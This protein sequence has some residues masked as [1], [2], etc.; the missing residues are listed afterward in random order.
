[1]AQL[2]CAA[3]GPRAEEAAQRL[4]ERFGSLRT[5]YSASAVALA[6]ALEDMGDLAMPTAAAVVATRRFA[7]AAAHEAFVGEPLDTTRTAFRDYLVRRIGTRREECVLVLYF[8]D[9]GLFL[10]EDIYPGGS[11]SGS[12][13]PLRRS[14]R[15]AFEL[16]ARRLVLAHNHPSGSSLPSKADIAATARFRQVVEP[17]EIALHDHCI[18]AG[19]AVASMRALRVL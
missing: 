13:I 9:K 2:V 18:V 19:G 3:A 5:V 11:R 15:R 1:M 17:L 12:L 10:A 6:G 4:I 8:T 16:D 7:E 14:V